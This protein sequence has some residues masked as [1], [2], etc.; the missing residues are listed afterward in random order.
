RALYTL[1]SRLRGN[2][3]VGAWEWREFCSRRLFLGCK[4]CQFSSPRLRSGSGT[5]RA[6][7]GDGPPPHMRRTHTLPAYAAAGAI[8]ASAAAAR[9]RIPEQAAKAQL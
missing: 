6:R 9:R 7:P 8:I 3:E 4:Q 1:D 2:G 5:C